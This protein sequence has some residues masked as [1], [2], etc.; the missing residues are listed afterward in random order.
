MILKYF[1]AIAIVCGLVPQ[2]FGQN[3]PPNNLTVSF[4]GQ[5]LSMTEVLS[6][7]L[8]IPSVS[9]NEKEAGQFLQQISKENGLYITP[10][11]QENGNFN[12]AASIAPLSPELPNIIFLNHLD[13]VPA[14]D[15][16]QWTHPPFSGK[17][18]DGDIWGRGAFD[19]KGP[20]I[21]QLFSIIETARQ[22]QGTQLPFNVTLLA[23]SCEETQCE[24]GIR[25]VL[26]NF[27]EQLNPTVVIGEGPPSIDQVLKSDPDQDL[28]GISVAHKRPLWLELEL[29]V[30]TSGHGSVTPVEYANKEMV[31]ALDRLLKRKQKAIYT[32]VNVDLLKQLGQ[33]EKGVNAFALK[34]PKFFKWAIIPKV[35]KQ[36]EMFALFSNTVT[37]TR[38]DSHNDV[39]NVIPSKITAHLDCRLMPGQ[40]TSDF[41]KEVRQRLRNDD[42]YVTVVH[43]A[44]AMTPSDDNHPF[45]QFLAGSLK[46]AYPDAEP[47][48]IMQPN[49]NDLGQFRARGITA[50]AST[51]IRMDR[52]YLNSIHQF[53]ER[54]PVAALEEGEAVFR[55]FILKCINSEPLPNDMVRK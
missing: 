46:A 47:I 14:G 41:I 11:G 7:Y 12:F 27:L 42:I 10:M 31:L 29:K 35:R 50:F 1:F 52:E 15:S 25:Y 44:P 30:T 53:N 4:K 54:I 8:Q 49:F 32:P 48:S 9:G 16:A 26:D 13:V 5:Q 38:M 37:L 3:S 33:L 6:H 2:G 21:M 39:I 43:E 28:F 40:T 22:F 51:P 24:G 19:N 34:N 36:P 55:D 45:Y 20:A 23:V 17:V 18:L